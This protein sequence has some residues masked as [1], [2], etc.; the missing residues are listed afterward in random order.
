TGQPQASQRV[1]WLITSRNE[2]HINQYLTAASVSL[3]DVENDLKYGAA[4]SESKRQHARDAVS[5]LRTSK[6]YGSDLAYYIRNSIDTLS[7]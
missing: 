4:I 5:Q 1:R 2:R 6:S 3:V 7:A